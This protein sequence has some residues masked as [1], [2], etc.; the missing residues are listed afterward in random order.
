MAILI[1]CSHEMKQKQKLHMWNN[2]CFKVFRSETLILFLLVMFALFEFTM[3][4]IMWNYS[5]LH[6]SRF[7]ISFGKGGSRMARCTFNMRQNTHSASLGQQERRGVMPPP[8]PA[9]FF[10]KRPSWTFCI[11][12]HY[13]CRMRHKGLC[14]ISTSSESVH[15]PGLPQCTVT[16]PR[17]LIISP[18]PPPPHTHTCTLNDTPKSWPSL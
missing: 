15:L 2:T 6:N 16:P 18:P 1:W 5:S 11:G 8:P 7:W 3:P 12:I 4:P 14:L 9:H 13:N 10:H 17:R